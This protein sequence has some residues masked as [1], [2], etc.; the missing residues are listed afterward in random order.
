LYICTLVRLKKRKRKRKRRKKRKRKQS[1]LV[2][3]E[4]YMCSSVD[5]YVRNKLVRHLAVVQY[6]SSEPQT[7]LLL[8]AE[9]DNRE[10]PSTRGALG[11]TAGVGGVHPGERDV[12]ATVLMKTRWPVAGARG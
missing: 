10:F 2:E 5:V 8:M 1:M 4:E 3:L 7:G 12:V 9:D 11:G 6:I